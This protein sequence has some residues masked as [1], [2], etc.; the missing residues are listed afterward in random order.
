MYSLKISQCNRSNVILTSKIGAVK[1]RLKQ[2]NR[3][4]LICDRS[5]SGIT[6]RNL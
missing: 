1:K 4:Q 5:V 2:I 6:C 3:G